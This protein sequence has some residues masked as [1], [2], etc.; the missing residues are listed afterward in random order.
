MSPKGFL[1]GSLFLVSVFPGYSQKPEFP[2]QLGKI[3]YVLAP[4][5]IA[6]YVTSN[7]LA[8]RDHNLSV[9]EI[10]ALDRNDV[11]RFDRNAT[12]NWNHSADKFSDVTHDLMPF[13][14]LVLIIPQLKNKKLNNAVTLGVMYA[15]V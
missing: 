2:Y 14:P 10:S 15:E 7:A 11:N 3:D 1:W 5:G 13:A 9:D 8:K 4:L 6:A 12:Y